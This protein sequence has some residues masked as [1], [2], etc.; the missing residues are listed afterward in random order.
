MDGSVNTSETCGCGLGSDDEPGES[1]EPEAEHAP[2]RVQWTYDGSIDPTALGLPDAA[3]FGGALR[4]L[5]LAAGAASGEIAVTVVGDGRMGDL[6]RRY[7]G[8]PTST[9][10]LSFDLG[11]GDDGEPGVLDADVVVCLDEAARQAGRRRGHPVRDELLLY[12]LHG[13]LHLLGYDDTD[14]RSA[15]RMHRRENEL[16]AEAGYGE[17]Y[18]DV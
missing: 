9:D 13:T 8:D 16:L 12:A 11:A 17:V 14:D 7:K 6:H 4:R 2:L 5:A 15:R 3:W 1:G 18:G 10:V